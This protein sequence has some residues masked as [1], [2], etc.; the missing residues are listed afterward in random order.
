MPTQFFD[1]GTY[2]GP[3]C[4]TV[5]ASTGASRPAC[6]TV[7]MAGEFSVRNTSAGELAPSSTI[8][9]PIEE[10][11]PYRTWTSMPVSSWNAWPQASV[12]FLC[13]AL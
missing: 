9:A 4:S 7:V 3:T 8:W 10:S 5:A 6:S 13:W 11:L 1:D 2:W 12:R